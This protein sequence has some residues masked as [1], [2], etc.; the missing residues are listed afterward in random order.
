[1]D[2]QTL[3]IILTIFVGV[4]ALAMLIQMGTL[5]ALFLTAKKL[6]GQ[7]TELMP[8]ISAVIGVSK[9]TADVTLRTIEGAEKHIQKIGETSNS[10]LDTTKL[11]VAKIDELLTD[12]TLRAKVQLE[13]AEMVLDDS[14]GRA[15]ETVSIVQRSILRPVR[16]I[17]GLVVGLRTTLAYLG[18]GSRPTV[19]HATADEEMF[20]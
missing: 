2:Q 3:L 17:N 14:M 15:Q 5:I 1:M 6:Q 7:V 11:Q 9:K 8:Q 10:I 18:R 19:D 16:E 13:R 4:A 20:I 12:A